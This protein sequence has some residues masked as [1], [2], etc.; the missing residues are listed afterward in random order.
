MTKSDLAYE[1]AIAS[2]A[3]EIKNARIKT[4]ESAIRRA[5]IFLEEHRHGK[6]KAILFET[7]I[8]GKNK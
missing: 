4:L 2:A 3:M 7:G 1:L 8:L 5:Y 6:A